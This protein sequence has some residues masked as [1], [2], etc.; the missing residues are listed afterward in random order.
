MEEA[1]PTDLARYFILGCV[2]WGGRR[3]A[4]AV[5]KVFHLPLDISDAMLGAL[6]R[7]PGSSL[8]LPLRQA[9]DAKITQAK[10]D[11]DLRI[12]EGWREEQISRSLARLALSHLE[13]ES[14]EHV[15]ENPQLALLI[16]SQLG[17][18]SVGLATVVV[19][20]GRAMG[21]KADDALETV[22]RR[23]FRRGPRS[24]LPPT[25]QIEQ[26][27][28][29]LTEPSEDADQIG[30]ANPGLTEPSED[31]ERGGNGHE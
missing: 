17:E 5:G 28:P 20:N 30:Q 24:T 22:A 7:L 4:D 1:D 31:V 25:S 23:L 29:G 19:D 9:L 14:L 13:D 3:T 18:Q 12:R 26:A 27:N 2:V 15:S 11:V 21:E 16:R 10:D 6:D 8:L